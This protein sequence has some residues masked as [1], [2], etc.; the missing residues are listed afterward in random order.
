[1]SALIGPSLSSNSH[2]RRSRPF[3][4]SQSQTKLPPYLRLARG[5]GNQ[6]C[7]CEDLCS[8]LR[9]HGCDSENR[10]I[11]FAGSDYD[12]PGFLQNS[13]PDYWNLPCNGDSKNHQP[14]R[15]AQ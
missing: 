1:M 7:R 2:Q 9:H 6:S 10:A 12:E 14:C 11:V 8:V 13:N 15:C 3:L 5:G 4:S